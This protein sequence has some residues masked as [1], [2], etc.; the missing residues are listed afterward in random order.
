MTACV[1]IRRADPLVGA[2][3]VS[4]AT[5][6][7]LRNPANAP[8]LRS[9]LTGVSGPSNAGGRPLVV[10]LSGPNLNLLGEREPA[11]YGAATLA[12]HVKV[13]TEHPRLDG[14]NLE[15]ICT[16]NVC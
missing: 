6:R 13:A 12:E 7:H 11:V 4:D 14:L 5:D 9:C 10:L 8:V 15:R 2:L 3:Q 16:D 1:D